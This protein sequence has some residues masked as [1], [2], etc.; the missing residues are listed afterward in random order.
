MEE[1]D[2]DVWVKVEGKKLRN[3]DKEVILNGKWLWGTHLTVVQLL[4]KKR[5]TD[6][7]GLID[8]SVFVH[9]DQTISTGS[10]QILHVNGN[11]WITISTMQ[12]S[13]SNF[14]DVVV[15]D[16]LHFHLSQ[17]TKVLLA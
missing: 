13:D 7:N 6:I 17:A 14:C 15:Y 1:I 8:A 4:L 2:N 11:H 16:S 9:K 12:C 10:V 5:Y 3:V